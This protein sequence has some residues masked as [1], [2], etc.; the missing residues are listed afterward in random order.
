[1]LHEDNFLINNYV[2][3]ISWFQFELITIVKVSESV[4][5]FNF[6]AYEN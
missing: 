1:M 2:D 6:I 5:N 4:I 3:I